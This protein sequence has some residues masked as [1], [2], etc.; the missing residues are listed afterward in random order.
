MIHSK[1]RKVASYSRQMK[2]WAF[3]SDSCF[4]KGSWKFLCGAWT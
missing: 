1:K 4:A 3:H 2:D